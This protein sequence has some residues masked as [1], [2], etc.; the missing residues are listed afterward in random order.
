MTRNH[1]RHTPKK[2]PVMSRWGAVLTR[3]PILGRFRM[4]DIAQ[5]GSDSPG[6]LNRDP[7]GVSL[8]SIFAK[9]PPGIP[10]KCPLA[11]R[12]GCPLT[13]NRVFRRF[14]IEVQGEFSERIR[15]LLA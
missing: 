15:W 9:L 7:E 1:P 2:L 4:W 10:E 11:C 3:R 13:P 12:L 14:K 6:Y 8:P 5:A